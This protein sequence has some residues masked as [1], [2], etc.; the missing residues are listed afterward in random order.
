MKLQSNNILENLTIKELK[1]L[2]TEIKETVFKNFKKEKK[3]NF[4][5]TDLW[6]IQRRKK[7]AYSKRF[8]F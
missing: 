8:V 1:N 2:T 7:S 3:R 4:T 6:D 5:T